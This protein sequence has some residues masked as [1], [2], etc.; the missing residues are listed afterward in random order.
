MKRFSHSAMQ[1]R[2]AARRGRPAWAWAWAW[3]WAV[4]W[5][6]LALLAGCAGPVLTPVDADLAPPLL[7]DEAFAPATEPVNA[8][9][10]FAL[11]PA[12]QAQLAELQRSRRT[13]QAPAQALL[14][15]LHD[16][17]QLQLGYDDDRTRTAA[18][19]FADRRGN[20]L[21]LAV[22]TAAFA[23]ALGLSVDYRFARFDAEALERNGTL[24]QHADHVQ[25]ALGAGLRNDW[26]STAPPL[27]IDFA[28]PDQAVRL[29]THSI[30]EPL[31]EAMYLNNRAVETLA[32]GR[33]HA[34]Y[35]WARA[36]VLR[37]P[38]WPAARNT[39]A[40]VYLR[41]GRPDL[42]ERT[43]A[44]LLRHAPQMGAALSNQAQALDALGRRADAMGLRARLATDDRD[45]Q[46]Y[47]AKA[48][49]LRAHAAEGPTGLPG[50]PAT[51]RL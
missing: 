27:L 35:W 16:R 31:V 41:A 10:L 18:E 34:A 23:K 36:A 42:A 26:R 28:P 32:A 1:G 29:V 46:R 37:Q 19:A 50:P 40:V 2:A 44:E 39:L 17:R 20:C 49:W 43:L 47:E 30:D 38:G 12:M 9:G 3:A 25:L 7:A 21:S 8:D 51:P 11:S 45:R 15:A 48:A 33:V 13:R 6:L 14:E 24:L 22:M 4:A 5:S